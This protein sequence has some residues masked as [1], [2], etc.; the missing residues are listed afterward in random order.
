MNKTLVLPAEE[1]PARAWR[2]VAYTLTP[3]VA[4]FGLVAI[5]GKACG[6]RS[7]DEAFFAV[8]DLPWIYP[9][10]FDWTVEARQRLDTFLNCACSVLVGACPYHQMLMEAWGQQDALRNRILPEEIPEALRGHLGNPANDPNRSRV[11]RPS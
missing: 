5:A 1:A 10:H 9:E 6:V 4:P 7:D 3:K 11:I 2:E 8:Y